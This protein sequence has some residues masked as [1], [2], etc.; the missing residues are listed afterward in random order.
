MCFR[1][2]CVKTAFRFNR[3]LEINFSTNVTVIKD[4]AFGRPISRRNGHRNSALSYQG[5]FPLAETRNVAIMTMLYDA[6]FD[7][8]RVTGSEVIAG[9]AYTLICL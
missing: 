5:Q 7:E 6:K 8:N 1:S 3:D 9:V 2:V 4:E